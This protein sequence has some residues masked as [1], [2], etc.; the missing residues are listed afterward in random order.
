[1][2]GDAGPRIEEHLSF[3]INSFDNL[4]GGNNGCVD[5]SEE[6][7]HF[8]G[9]SDVCGR[10]MD[11]VQVNAPRSCSTHLP[12]PTGTNLPSRLKIASS[13]HTTAPSIRVHVL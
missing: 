6:S 5:R 8:W 7:I 1:M 4:T 11:I 12:T 9:F 2:A 10:I 3:F 13:I